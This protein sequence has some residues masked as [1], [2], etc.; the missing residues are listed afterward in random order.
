[1]SEPPPKR[2]KCGNCKEEGHD[3]RN[4][5]LIH[6]A[7][8]RNL[9]ADGHDNQNGVGG[10]VSQAPSAAAAPPVHANVNWDKVCY[11]LFD[12]EM[13]GGSRTD[14]DIIKLAAMILGLDGIALEDGSFESLVRPSKD[15]W[16]FIASLTGI[17]N[18]MVKTASDFTAVA[19]EFFQFMSDTAKSQKSCN[20]DGQ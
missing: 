6:E 5:P 3:C 11:V 12:L 7:S 13:T 15:I 4:C 10:P 1:M 19:T 16:T 8:A 2:R 9:A 14:D 18:D 20:S 17:T